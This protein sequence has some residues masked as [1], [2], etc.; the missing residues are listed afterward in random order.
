MYGWLYLHELQR[1]DAGE[2]GVEDALLY[3]EDRLHDYDVTERTDELTDDDDEGQ[4][5]DEGEG[6]EAEIDLQEHVKVT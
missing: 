2:S 3:H 1:C 4:E 5:P 6:E